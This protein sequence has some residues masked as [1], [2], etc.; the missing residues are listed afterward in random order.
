MNSIDKETLLYISIMSDYPGNFVDNNLDSCDTEGHYEEMYCPHTTRGTLT[1]FAQWSINRKWKSFQMDWGKL[2][3]YFG[4]KYS[5]RKMK[6]VGL[7]LQTF[8][9]KE[10]EAGVVE[11]LATNK[12][13]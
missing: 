5:A 9:L 11:K 10:L 13:K 6:L 7:T 1:N 8:T 12:N 4:G 3:E 2:E